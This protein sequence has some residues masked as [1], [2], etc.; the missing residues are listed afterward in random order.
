VPLPPPPVSRQTNR[1]GVSRSTQPANAREL[2]SVHERTEAHP[3][4]QALRPQA[5]GAL[6][7]GVIAGWWLGQCIRASRPTPLRAR[8]TSKIGACGAN[9][10]QVGVGAA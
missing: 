3:L 4:H 1:W 10:G 6:P 7:G 2:A 9:T 5:A 8:E